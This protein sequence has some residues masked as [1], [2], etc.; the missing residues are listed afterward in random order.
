M[1]VIIG[2][3]NLCYQKIHYLE[4]FIIKRLYGA[5]LKE[6]SLIRCLYSCL[7]MPLTLPTK[8]FVSLTGIKLGIF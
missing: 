1:R 7:E 5:A 8:G 3:C 4:T 6:D 2:V